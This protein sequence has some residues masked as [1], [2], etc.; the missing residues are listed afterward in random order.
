MRNLSFPIWAFLACALVSG[1]SSLDM[2]R[3]M[4]KRYEEPQEGQRARLRVVSDGLVRAVPGSSCVD[5]K[6]PGSGVLVIDRSGA[7]NHN[8]RSLGMPASGYSNLA[9]TPGFVGAE[10]QVAANQPIVLTY[11]SVAPQRGGTFGRCEATESFIPEAG[12]DYEASF[13]QSGLQ[14][15]VSVVQRQPE[16]SPSVSV[17]TLPAGGC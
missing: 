1:C 10:V 3:S 5:W 11:L 12:A 17:S 4:S 7:P 16:G 8:G 15:Y 2:V 9:R 6:K 14:C 13:T